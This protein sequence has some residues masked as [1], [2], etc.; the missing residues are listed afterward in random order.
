MPDWYESSG[1]VAE[2]TN[3]V[4][5]GLL[6]WAEKTDTN[7]ITHSNITEA[8]RSLTPVDGDG[9]VSEYVERIVKHGPFENTGVGVWDIDWERVYS[10]DEYATTVKE[11][12]E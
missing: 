1:P 10:G 9:T 12:S 3:T 5:N 8:T 6:N 7:R 11:E 4:I 2:R